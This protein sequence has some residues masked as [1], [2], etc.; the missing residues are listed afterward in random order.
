MMNRALKFL[1]VPVFCLCSMSVFGQPSNPSGDPDT[2][3]IGGIEILIAAGAALGI[4]KLISA[5]KKN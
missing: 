5:K 1:L 3:P 4:K 2:V